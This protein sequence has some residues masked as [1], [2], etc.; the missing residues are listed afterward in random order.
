MDL[1]LLRASCAP[2]GITANSVLARNL[3]VIEL[4]ASVGADINQ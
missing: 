1:F 3:A 2:L 4:T